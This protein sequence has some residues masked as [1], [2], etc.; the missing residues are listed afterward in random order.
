MIARVPR[1]LAHRGASGEALENSLAAFELARR[2]GADGV[3]LDIRATRDGR[4]VVHHDSVIPGLGPIRDQLFP[5][6]QAARLQN[7]EPIPTL[8]EALA[9]L[10]GL[11]VWIEV[12]ALPEA[13]DSTLLRTIAE[14]PTPVRCAVHSFD[15]RII[16]RLGSKTP[17]LR[18]GILSSSY[19]VD[20]VGPM[21]EASAGT[22]WQE[23]P[24]ID[25]ELVAA[26]HRRGGEIIAWT[27]NDPV[28][29]RSLAELGVDGVCGNYPARLLPH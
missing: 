4:L 10:A 21:A 22:L 1:I 9:V 20:P 18:R 28:V 23:W 11:E 29:F 13:G 7:G 16:A 2:Q 14:S 15:H 17:A 24:L 5:A 25:A 3:E 19:P 27:V 8:E 12:K 26:V 6:L